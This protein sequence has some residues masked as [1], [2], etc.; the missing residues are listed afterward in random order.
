MNEY[1]KSLRIGEPESLVN[2]F[3]KKVLKESVE[4]S[5][6]PISLDLT[7]PPIAELVLNYSDQH[8]CEINDAIM[9]VRHSKTQLSSETGARIT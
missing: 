3:E 1:K 5:E 8:D 6:I 9:E 7:I 4:N 2:Y